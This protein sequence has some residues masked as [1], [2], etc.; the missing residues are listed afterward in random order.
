M[1]YVYRLGNVYVH[2]RF[3]TV[4]LSLCYDAILCIVEAIYA[5]TRIT[6]N[7]KAHLSVADMIQYVT[8]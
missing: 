4:E 5:F 1:L 7:H 3:C 6:V 2:R 8:E